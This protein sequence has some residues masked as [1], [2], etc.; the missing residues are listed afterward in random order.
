ME[1]DIT[2]PVEGRFASFLAADGTLVCFDEGLKTRYESA[3]GGN[4][5]TPSP[6][7]GS[8]GD[9]YRDAQTGTFLPDGRLIVYMWEEGLILISPDGGSESYPIQEID[10]AITNGENVSVSLLQALGNDRFLLGYSI[11]GM[12]VQATRGGTPAGGNFPQEAGRDDTSDEEETDGEN[13][14]APDDEFNG[15]TGP[16]NPNGDQVPGGGTAPTTGQG[17]QDAAQRPGG[18]GFSGQIM[19]K[20]QLYDISSG[21]LIAEI[22]VESAMGAACDDEN[23]YVLD[24]VGKV[25]AYTMRDGAPIDRQAVNFGGGNEEIGMGMQMGGT[26][27]GSLAVDAGGALYSVQNGS[28][29][30][31][32]ADGV[33]D[34]VLQSTAYSTGTPRSSVGAVF[35]LEDGGIVV[36][37]LE[38]G[39]ANR[40]YK[41]VWDENAAIDPDKT[42]TVWSLTDNS[43]VRAA[44]AQLRK[45]Y[46]DAA[47]TYEVAMDA[48][49]A[50]S[51]DDAIKTL[52]TELLSGN[53]PDI[54]LLD[55]CPADSY[56]DKGMLLDLS[57]LI[58]TSDIYDN[59]LNPYKKDGELYCLP[60]QFLMPMLMGSADSLDGIKTQDDLISLVVEGNDLPAG[61]N[62][63][64][65]PFT[66]V[67]ESKRA[68]LYFSDLK[69]LCDILWL[70]SAPAIVGDNKL[71]TDA[72]RSYLEAILSI[73][74]KY[75]LTERSSGNRG[76]RAR[77]V[78]GGS[79]ATTVPD[80]LMWYTM[81]MTNY[82]AFFAGNLQLLQIMMERD[83]SELALFPG[84][85]PDA[86]QPSTVISVS[87]D[88]AVPEFA[89]EFVENMLSA[90]VQQLNYGT[91][92]P[93][94]R[95]GFAAQ[96]DA[97]NERRIENGQ[98]LFSAFDPDALIGR[99]QTPSMA[100]TVLTEMM[101]STVEKCCKGQIDVEGAVKEIE[102]NVKNYLAE[103]S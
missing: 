59:L 84:L 88:T 37:M 58:D 66:A 40:L 89:A 101:W 82:A 56:A 4:S 11:G 90:A 63:G 1:S 80:S 44:I 72:L 7:P 10:D 39:Q 47:I 21:R 13:A 20:T 19:A 17:P 32:G 52:N 79:V 24:G 60:T 102:Q 8:D 85:A 28:L 6:G 83:G 97:I 22:P 41:Y 35:V 46:P 76:P 61:G 100:D 50:V 48:S 77:F 57:G 93:V 36:N 42:L 45:T 64:S 26:V 75:A 92:L 18:G 14:P 71:N 53:G 34:T 25:T 38:N 86:W 98:P 96:I 12:M 29:L 67:E 99:L 43:F 5:W 23:L 3:D 62:S 9:R 103:R 68:A 95:T 69:D 33:V 54:I 15:A 78:D 55:G 81:E 51:A 27:G 74:D 70:S 65:G 94:T 30:R 16:D 2:P 73:S 49:N 87:A 91:G 31:A